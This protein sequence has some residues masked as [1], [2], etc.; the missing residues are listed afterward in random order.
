MLSPITTK[1]DRHA[2]RIRILQKRLTRMEA[3][4]VDQLHLLKEKFNQTYLRIN[5]SDKR[6]NKIDETLLEYRRA[7]MLLDNTCRALIKQNN[8]LTENHNVLHNHCITMIQGSLTLQHNAI[9][10]LDK[11]EN[12]V[13]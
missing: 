1:R 2:A 4:N 3:D 11:L 5:S 12:K 7:I 6:I 13:I 9:K 10:R 8:L